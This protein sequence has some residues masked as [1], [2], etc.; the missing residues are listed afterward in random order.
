MKNVDYFEYSYGPD[1]WISKDIPDF[2]GGWK[3]IDY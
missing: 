3:Y 2:T 1:N